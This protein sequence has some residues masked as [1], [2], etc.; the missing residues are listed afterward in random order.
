MLGTVAYFKLPVR[1][2][3]RSRFPEIQISANL[4]GAS[5]ENDGIRRRDAA[6]NYCPRTCPASHR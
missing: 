2:R 6:E 5:A 3:S 1:R 4:P